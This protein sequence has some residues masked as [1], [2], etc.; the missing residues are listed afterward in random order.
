MQESTAAPSTRLQRGVRLYH[1]QGIQI[2]QT[3]GGTYI[4]PS[5]TGDGEYVVYADH[6]F[7]FCSCP[8]HRRAVAAN[9]V[10]KHRAA[11]E[12]VRAKRRARRRRA[13]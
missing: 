3:E 10:C 13:A 8:D 11:V 7:S 4:V 9:E 2:A 6:D 12:I 5:C 1:E